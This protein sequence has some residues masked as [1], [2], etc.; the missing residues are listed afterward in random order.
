MPPDLEL[1]IAIGE[2]ISSPIVLSPRWE[3]WFDG[4]AFP[5]PGRVGIGGVLVGPQGQQWLISRT[6]GFGDSS[7]AEYRALIA[8]LEMASEFHV[9]NLIIH[10]DSRV[11]IDDLSGLAP[12]RTASLRI[13]GDKARKLRE[14]F[15]LLKLVWI[16]R[17]KNSRADELANSAH[18][19]S[20]S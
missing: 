10:G 20:I 6:E 4:S 15:T 3:A 8:V 18:V 1:G 14:N 12:I 11:V 17:R 19:A 7:V 2:E 5:N 16:P 9:T 13:L